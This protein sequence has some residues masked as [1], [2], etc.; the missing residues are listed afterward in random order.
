M[1]QAVD[2]AVEEED[3]AT[4]NRSKNTK[5]KSLM[6]SGLLPEWF[7]NQ[8]NKSL[9]MKAGRVDTQRKLVNLA[10]DRDPSSGKLMLNTDK[11]FFKTL[12]DCSWKHEGG[13]TDGW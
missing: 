5:F 4:R 2:F 13:F 3:Q 11:G 9:S 7:A 8:W 6:K 12:K 1:D 10:I